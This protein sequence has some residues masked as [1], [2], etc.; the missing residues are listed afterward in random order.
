MWPKTGD[1]WASLWD[2]GSAAG[3]AEAAIHTG[4]REAASASFAA[5]AA[6]LAH[7][8]DYYAG[9]GYPSLAAEAGALSDRFAGWSQSPPADDYEAVWQADPA[10]S[11]TLAH[12]WTRASALTRPRDPLVWVA[13]ALA[14]AAVT[15]G[16][17][18]WIR[19]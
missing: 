4:S 13:L 15:V 11:G 2:V 8:H 18:V 14:A 10:A 9:A 5:G 7:A 17:I 12:L 1:P 19:R 6:T 16:V 3:S